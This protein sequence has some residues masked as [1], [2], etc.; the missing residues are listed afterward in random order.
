MKLTIGRENEKGN[1][2]TSSFSGERI[3]VFGLGSGSWVLSLIYQ[4]V[5]S[6]ETTV[7]APTTSAEWRVPAAR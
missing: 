2:G 1:G 7:F 3:L 4:R 5:P 6:S